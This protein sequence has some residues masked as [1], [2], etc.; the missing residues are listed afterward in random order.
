MPTTWTPRNKPTINIAPL[1]DAYREVCNED[2]Q[3][4]YIISNT[5]KTIPLT[6]WQARP[7]I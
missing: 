6:I 2:N 1:Q 4:I 3:V 7:S 5:W